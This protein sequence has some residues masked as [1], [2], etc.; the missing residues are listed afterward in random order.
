MVSLTSSQDAVGDNVPLL[1]PER[2]I[3][4]EGIGQVMTE[5]P[6]FLVALRPGFS[7]TTRGDEPFVI[8]SSLFH[9]CEVIQVLL[10]H[11]PPSFFGGWGKDDVVTLLKDAFS[12]SP[13]V[14][15]GFRQLS[16]QGTSMDVLRHLILFTSRTSWE[17]LSL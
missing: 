17:R 16:A 3:L 11:F 15:P 14:T 9:P 7:P 1:S 10:L 2:F 8:E 6:I 13:V 5:D 12:E 4:G